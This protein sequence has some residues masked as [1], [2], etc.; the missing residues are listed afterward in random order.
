MSLERS[1]PINVFQSLVIYYR[2]NGG[3]IQKQTFCSRSSQHKI[4]ENKEPT[5]D[6]I[7]YATLIDIDL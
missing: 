3:D 4:F 7:V 5:S 1:W 2:A 6:F